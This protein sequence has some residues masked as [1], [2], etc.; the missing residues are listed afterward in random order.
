MDH[1]VMYIIQ[2]CTTIYIV[3]STSYNHVHCTAMYILQYK[4]YT[5]HILNHFSLNLNKESN[6][7]QVRYSEHMQGIDLISIQTYQ[8]YNA[9]KLRLD[10]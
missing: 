10:I 3:H 9:I 6:K 8:L 2:H 7:T 1:S 4:L 5:K